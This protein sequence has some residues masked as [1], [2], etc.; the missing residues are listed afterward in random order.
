PALVIGDAPSP[1]GASWGDDGSIVMA[2]NSAHPLVR[3][4]ASGGTSQAFIPMRPDER[5]QRWPQVLPGSRAVIF[6][7][8]TANS[9]YDHARIDVFVTKTGERRTLVQ[10]GFSGRYIDSGHLVYLHQNTLF[11]VPFNL[12]KLAVT[13]QATPV[14]DSVLNAGTTGGALAVS[15]TG[16]AVYLEGS[17]VRSS[18]AI[19]RI[20]GA[21]KRELLH[22]SAGL[23]APRL[24][25]DGKRIA[26]SHN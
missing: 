26:F 17:G 21:G 10:D 9:D 24:A 16:R 18:G 12:A 23:I 25:P 15:P 7:S 13:G 19:F 8:H 6:T 4:P 2:A 11:A 22:E 3:I 14:L 5:T 20:D 1:R